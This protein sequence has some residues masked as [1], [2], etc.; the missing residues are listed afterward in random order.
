MLGLID[1]TIWSISVSE[2]YVLTIDSQERVHKFLSKGA[3]FKSII[4]VKTPK[5]SKIEQAIAFEEYSLM[6]IKEKE[7]SC[8]TYLI[9]DFEGE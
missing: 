1:Y 7:N 6:I 5:D 3:D 8:Q 4:Q 2:K 9:I